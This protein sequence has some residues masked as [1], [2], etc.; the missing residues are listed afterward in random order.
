MNEFNHTTL[1]CRLTKDCEVK[2]LNDKKTLARFTVAFDTSKK[3]EMGHWV[4]ESNFIDCT[5][6]S[7]GY[8][9]DDL[10]KGVQ[11]VIT[12]SLKQDKWEKDGQKFSKLVL[13]VDDVLIGKSKD[14]SDSLP[15]S[16]QDK[17]KTGE[18]V[19]F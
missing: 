3:D 6:F 12:G 5:Y 9:L 8:L 19:P 4:N 11:V 15:D 2:Q 14:K 1:K 18:D 10:K 13:M 16:V 7:N 17:P